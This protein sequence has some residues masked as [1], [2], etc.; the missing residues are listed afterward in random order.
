MSEARTL[1]EMREIVIE[2]A[3]Q[4]FTRAAASP[5]V[6]SACATGA[7]FTRAGA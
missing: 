6:V 4:K 7:T 1:L 2:D 3:G 5:E